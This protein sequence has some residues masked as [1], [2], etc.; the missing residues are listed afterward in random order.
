MY[1]WDETKRIANL[2]KH[3]VDF[4]D[5]VWFDWSRSVVDVDAR[6]DYREVRLLAYAPLRQRLH[7]LIYTLRDGTVR[8]ISL[9]KANR[10]ETLEWAKRKE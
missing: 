10:R 8:I 9:R 3:G 2:A 1:D 7:A 6:Q 4:A 5:I